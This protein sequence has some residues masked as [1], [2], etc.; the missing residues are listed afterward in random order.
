MTKRQAELH[1]RKNQ[2]H[3]KKK[4]SAPKP[5]REHMAGE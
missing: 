2:E 5:A 1:L 3:L 4:A